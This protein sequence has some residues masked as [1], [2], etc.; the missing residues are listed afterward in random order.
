MTLSL[1]FF[2]LLLM[3]ASGI[4]IGA[5]IEGTRFLTEN[6]SKRSFVFK[7]RV[8]LEVIIWILLGLGTFYLL[9]EVRDGIWRVYDPL[10]QLVGILFYEQFFQ[11]IFRLAGRIFLRLIVKPIWFVIHIFI[12]IVHKI[13]RLFVNIIRAIAQPFHFLYKKTLHLALQK[14]PNLRYNKKYTKN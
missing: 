14:K 7:Y 2:S 4:L 1:Q 9:Y 13:L 6:F 10:A 12:T 3:M 11:P 5:I 8:G